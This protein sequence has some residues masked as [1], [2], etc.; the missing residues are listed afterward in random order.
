MQ[1]SI[2]SVFRLCVQCRRL[3]RSVRELH[4][5]LRSCSS[6]LPVDAGRSAT[7]IAIVRRSRNVSWLRLWLANSICFGLEL[8]QRAARWLLLLL[9]WLRLLSLLHECALVAFLHLV[10]LAR[11]R[12]CSVAVEVAKSSSSTRIIRILS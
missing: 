9:L 6:C 7:R 3:L 5:R 4:V 8:W 11:S 2:G 1:W 10:E 12:S